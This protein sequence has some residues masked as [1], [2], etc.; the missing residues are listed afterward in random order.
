MKLYYCDHIA[1]PVT[2]GSRFPVDK[3]RR[4]RDAITNIAGD[5]FELIQAEPVSIETLQLAHDP[6]YVQAICDGAISEHQQKRIGFPWS[7]AL[8][9]RSR[10]SVGA[11]I[12]ACKAA[13]ADGVSANLA[14]GTHHARTS[15]GAGYCVF[16][17][18]AVA[19]RLLVRKRPSLRL[20]IV[21]ADVHQGDGTASI[22][23]KDQNIYTF[24]IHCM[25][26]YPAR[27]ESSHL[28]VPLMAGV[29]D[30]EYMRQFSDGLK[31]AML[32]ARPDFM[33]YLA[34]AD[35]YS[36]D[37]LGKLALTKAGLA[38]RDQIVFDTCRRAFLPIAVVMGGGYA[39]NVD[40]IVA[41]H[42][43]TIRLASELVI[44]R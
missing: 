21:D 3:Y 37:R 41:I 6:A 2:K 29:G 4:L 12:A 1:I 20:L 30:A 36:E 24:S 34:G 19:S 8:V 25:D 39:P 40:D 31:R 18:I 5:E 7:D 32:A 11:T 13:L 9:A 42:V 17:D 26:N 14:G 16:N 23:N 33:I 35:P 22:L 43:T 10:C 44:K 38:E 28:D 15:A 27:K